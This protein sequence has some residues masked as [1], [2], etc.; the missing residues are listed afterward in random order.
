M[1]VVP[2]DAKVVLRGVAQPGPPYVF[3]LRPGQHFA[4]EVAREGYVTRRAVIDGSAPELT[5]S[6]FYDTKAHEAEKN[7]HPSSKR[8]ATKSSSVNKVQ[9]GL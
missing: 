7:A 2:H 6:L 4:V 1:N 5:V 3:E 9:S 8:S